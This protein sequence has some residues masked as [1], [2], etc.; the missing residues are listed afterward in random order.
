M[1]ELLEH[2]HTSMEYAFSKLGYGRGH[3][4]FT[5]LSRWNNWIQHGING[6]LFQM[7]VMD[8]LV[9]EFS[10]TEE[11]K[12]EV[13]EEFLYRRS[14]E[15][16]VYIKDNQTIRYILTVKDRPPLRWHQFGDQ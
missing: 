3:Y 12:I 13:D 8:M 10:F 11:V 1:D 16:G 2:L 7:R 15:T 9:D 6:E 5:L 14:P 4:E